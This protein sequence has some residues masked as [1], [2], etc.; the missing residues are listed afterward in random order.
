VVVAAGVNGNWHGSTRRVNEV[1]RGLVSSHR[2]E[3]F[4]IGGF[5]V[6]HRA[7]RVGKVNSLD[8]LINSYRPLAKELNDFGRDSS[9]KKGAKNNKRSKYRFVLKCGA[10]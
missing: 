6:K 3:V 7:V 1:K 4:V 8:G 2:A 10:L 9:V 5:R